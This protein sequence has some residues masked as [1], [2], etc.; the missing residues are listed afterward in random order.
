MLF[1]CT[2]AAELCI[3]ALIA[4]TLLTVSVVSKPSKAVT[5]GERAASLL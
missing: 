2:G 4:Q 5:I 3:P 1:L